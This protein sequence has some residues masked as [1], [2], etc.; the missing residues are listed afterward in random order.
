MRLACCDED[1]QRRDGRY[2]TEVKGQLGVH[3]KDGTLQGMMVVRAA[4][5]ATSCRVS[6][7]GS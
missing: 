2:I 6:T 7:F 1:Q 5:A 3:E 4:P